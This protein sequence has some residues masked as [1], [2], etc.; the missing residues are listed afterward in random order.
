MFGVCACM[1]VS[2]CLYVLWGK[3]DV[4]FFLCVSCFPVY[5]MCG[6]YCSACC[7]ATEP[8]GL[9]SRHCSV[10]CKNSLCNKKQQL[11]ETMFIICV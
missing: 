3:C 10:C 8:L 9:K 4:T 11:N 5:T 6:P 1:C 7:Q 2:V